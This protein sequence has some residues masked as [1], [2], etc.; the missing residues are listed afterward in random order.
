MEPDYEFLSAVHQ[1]RSR[2]VVS[3]GTSLVSGLH[4]YALNYASL[5]ARGLDQTR[6]QSARVSWHQEAGLAFQHTLLEDLPC[7]WRTN[8][9]VQ[10]GSSNRKPV[11]V[12]T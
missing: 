3:L 1:A 9:C 10:G 5:Q 2:S 7:R 11:T 4:V 12:N 8:R 6:L